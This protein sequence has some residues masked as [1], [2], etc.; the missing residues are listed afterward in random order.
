MLYHYIKKT[1]KHI[2]V[3]TVFMSIRPKT[4]RSFVYLHSLTTLLCNKDFTKDDDLL[5]HIL[6]YYY[7]YHTLYI[8]EE[9][10]RAQIRKAG[11]KIIKNAIL[12][13]F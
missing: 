8:Y 2:S 12:S 4:E 6:L 7:C 11:L 5:H 9:Y 3:D 10:I 13:G 1:T